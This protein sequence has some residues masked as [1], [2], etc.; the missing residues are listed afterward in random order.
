MIV[1]IASEGLLFLKLISYVHYK[2][3]EF[4]SSFLLLI[5]PCHLYV[6]YHLPVTARDREERVQKVTVPRV[7]RLMLCPEERRGKGC[8]NCLQDVYSWRGF[9]IPN[10]LRTMAN[11]QI[12]HQSFKN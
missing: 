9:S 5:F 12:T 1:S 10:I 2:V 8:I 11:T 7:P 3:Y 4:V 6:N